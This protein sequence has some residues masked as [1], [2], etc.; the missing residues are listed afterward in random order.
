[1][2]NFHERT[3]TLLYK[4]IPLT[5]YS[6]KVWCWLCVRGELEKGTDCYILNPNSSDYRSTSFT[7]WLGWLNLGSLRTQA[8]CLELV[9]TLLAS[10]LQLELQLTQGVCGTWLYNCLSSTCIL[11]AYASATIT[12]FNHVHRSRLYSDIFNQIHRFRCS[13]TYL[14]RCISWLTARSRVTM[15]QLDS[16]QDIKKKQDLSK[17]GGSI[18]FNDHLAHVIFKP[19]SLS[20]NTFLKW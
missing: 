13:S 2:S 19:E 16:L 14:H 5:L 10:Y 20:R 17:G 11:W 7:F 9:L 8:L 1:M 6:R 4:N 12:E 18:F 3:N 15:L